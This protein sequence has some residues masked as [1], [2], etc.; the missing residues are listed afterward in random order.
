MASKIHTDNPNHHQYVS[1][2]KRERK[3]K[4]KRLIRLLSLLFPRLDF[5]SYGWRRH[6]GYDYGAD[7]E[8]RT[9]IIYDDCNHKSYRK[10]VKTRDGWKVVGDSN[11]IPLK[12]RYGWLT[13]YKVIIHSF[14]QSSWLYEKQ[15]RHFHK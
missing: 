1:V 15:V 6:W 7:N 10:M 12:N 5:E 14:R 8:P 9:K 4:P 2:N 3:K 13:R 11:H